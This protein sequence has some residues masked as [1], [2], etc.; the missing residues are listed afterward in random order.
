MNEGG[1]QLHSGGEE[2]SSPF[3]VLFLPSYAFPTSPSG[4]GHELL[5]IN[6]Y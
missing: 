5:I 2:R 1:G 3:R 6:L 4:L